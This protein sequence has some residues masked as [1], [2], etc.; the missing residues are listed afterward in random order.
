MHDEGFNTLGLGMNVTGTSALVLSH[1]ENSEN[2]RMP[3]FLK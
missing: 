3:I 2:P 1:R